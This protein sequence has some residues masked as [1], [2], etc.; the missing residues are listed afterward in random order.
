LAN[1]FPLHKVLDRWKIGPKKLI[2]T[3]LFDE[4]DIKVTRSTFD[5]VA[6]AGL[7][8]P[9]DIKKVERPTWIPISEITRSEEKSQK[10]KIYKIASHISG[11]KVLKAIWIDSQ[12]NSIMDGHHRYEACKVLGFKKI[13]V[14]YV[15]LR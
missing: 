4:N 7:V 9:G 15:H 10:D 3:K 2:K 8:S 11:K 13:P 14:Q 5:D 1:H 12:D 6:K